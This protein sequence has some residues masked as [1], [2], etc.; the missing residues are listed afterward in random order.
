MSQNSLGGLDDLQLNESEILAAKQAAARKKYRFM[1]LCISAVL[2]IALG[3]LVFDLCRNST[4]NSPALDSSGASTQLESTGTNMQNKTTQN[5]PI[6]AEWSDWMD[7]LPAFAT[8]EDYLIEEQV[9]YSTISGVTGA[10]TA[11]L[12]FLATATGKSLLAHS[13]DT[14]IVSLSPHTIFGVG[15]IGQIGQQTLSQA[16]IINKWRQCLTIAIEIGF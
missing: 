15:A 4:T 11:I 2:V 13:T 3:C 14:G 10:V 1:T 7:S 16:Q 12:M 8:A 9:L 5:L 6:Q